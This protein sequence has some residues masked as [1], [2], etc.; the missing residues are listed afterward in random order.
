[1]T[2]HLIGLGLGDEHDI[3]LR[4]LAIVR[5]ADVIFLEHYTSTLGVDTKRLEQ[6]YGRE[7]KLADRTI[8]E[9]RAEQLLEPAKKQDVALLVV[10]DPFGAT[11]HTDLVLRAKDAGVTVN[12]VHNAS[13]MNA[14]GVVGLE[15]YKYGRTTSIPYWSKGFEP[16]TP[17]NAIKEN[18]E[19][20]LHTLCL[21]DIKMEEKR[22]RFM[23][24]N[25]ALGIL[26][27]LE[28]RRGERVVLPETLVVG[29]ARLG[30]ERQLI[31]AGPVSEL[32]ERDFGKP[33]HSLIVP[34]DLHVVEEEAL[35]Q[36]R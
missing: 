23:T 17:Y 35:A 21:L 2:L 28:R 8:I 15:L 33:L 34:G 10:G 25:E 11:T 7:V 31:Q 27:E 32:R 29:V 30:Q 20:G 24:I 13:I 36:W 5:R 6:L 9:Q 12:V 19:R 22:P 3:S 18:S 1:M 26:E 16:E 14:V 4:G